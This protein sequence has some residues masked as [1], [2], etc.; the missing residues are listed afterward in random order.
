MTSASVPLFIYFNILSSNPE[1][2]YDDN[3]M[4]IY[5]VDE[6]YK[7]HESKNGKNLSQRFEILSEDEL[8]QLVNDTCCQ[9]KVYDL[10]YYNPN[11][12]INKYN[13][14]IENL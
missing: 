12:D 3:Y 6:G 11:L 4:V 14:F 2:L 10:L 13:D 7:I 5:K 8:Y 1:Y 9:E